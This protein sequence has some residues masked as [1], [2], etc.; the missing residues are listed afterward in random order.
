MDAA[1]Q[2][3]P[4]FAAALSDGFS[5]L[6]EHLLQHHEN[7]IAR[8]K[9]ECGRLQ[10]EVSVLRVHLEKSNEHLLSLDGGCVRRAQTDPASY[11]TRSEPVSVQ[12]A[13]EIP[14]E[15][16][17]SPTVS[18]E[19]SRGTRKG[20][21][22][23][24]APAPLTFVSPAV[25]FNDK[26][27]ISKEGSAGALSAHACPPSPRRRRRG[28]TAFPGEGSRSPTRQRTMEP[29]ARRSFERSKSP[30][31]PEETLAI[32]RGLFD[33]KTPRE[34][35]APAPSEASKGLSSA[36]GS[37]GDMLCVAPVEAGA[38]TQRRRRRPTLT[39]SMSSQL[40][41]GGGAQ[42]EGA[43]QG[44]G[45]GARKGSLG[46]LSV[47]S[48][49]QAAPG[50][51]GAS[52]HSN[53]SSR[54]GDH[55]HLREVWTHGPPK[56][57]GSMAMRAYTPRRAGG[58]WTV[59]PSFRTPQAINMA[60]AFASYSS[61]RGER[62]AF[63]HPASRARLIWELL[64]VILVVYDVLVVPMYPFDWPAESTTGVTDWIGRTFWTA[65]IAMSFLTGVFVDFELE[66]RLREV[67]KRYAKSWMTFDVVVVLSEWIPVLV[68][69]TAA[70]SSALRLLRFA[71]ILRFLKMEKAFEIF[72]SVC[73]SWMA[74]WTNLVARQC[75]YLAAGIHLAACGWFWAGSRSPDGWVARE[76][77]DR[78]DVDYRYLTS[79]HWAVSQLHGASKVGPG[80]T[81]ESLYAILTL[82]LGLGSLC[83]LIAS[84][85]SGVMQLE[86]TRSSAAKQRVLIRT[87]LRKNNI[88]REL[89]LAVKRCSDVHTRAQNREKKQDQAKEAVAFLPLNL[90]M[91]ID[92]EVRGPVVIAYSFFADLYEGSTRI[93]R[94]LCHSCC[95]EKAVRPAEA[96]FAAG[97]DC[98]FMYFVTK[99]AFQY[100][101]ATRREPPSSR[102]AGDS[103]TKR[104]SGMSVLSGASAHTAG[105][106]RS[107]EKPAAPVP[108]YRGERAL[109]RGNWLCEATLW[110]TW[111]HR[112]VLT[113]STGGALLR[114]D[115]AEFGA[116]I[117]KHNAS[118]WAYASRYGR[119]FVRQLNECLEQHSWSDV[120]DGIIMI[121]REEI[122]DDESDSETDQLVE[123]D[124]RAAG[125]PRLSS[126][127]RTSD[128][129]DRHYI[130]IS[131]HKL[132]AGTE[133]TLM[134][135]ALERIIGQDEESPGH[136][137]D[138]PVF[139]D[140]ED[141]S[142]LTNLKDHVR[143]TFN[144]VLLLTEDVLK[145]PWVLIEIV[146][147]FQS[148]IHV[149]PVE[150]YK[151]D[152]NS[153]FKY[154][155]EK[156]YQRLHDGGLLTSADSAL[157]R[158]EGISMD[159]LE[160]ALRHVFRK[161]A[162]PF[163]PHKSQNVREAELTDILNRCT[164]TYRGSMTN[165]SDSASFNLPGNLVGQ[166][167]SFDKHHDSELS[168][169]CGRFEQQQS[170]TTAPSTDGG[171]ASAAPSLT[172][173][174]CRA[175]PSAESRGAGVSPL[176]L[177]RVGEDLPGDAVS[178]T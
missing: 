147:A 60:G 155:D 62:M 84:A 75:L 25:S 111:K 10:K 21:R 61:E 12:D 126:S 78:T 51:V 88:S 102:P 110:T 132:D 71:R 163:S 94:Q 136:H 138:A 121:T 76:N 20:R 6:K 83:F 106:L 100:T 92:E 99:G 45:L 40:A 54:A 153:P 122:L 113:T 31:T 29:Q 46:S 156:F 98:A 142:D 52:V 81:L 28:Q 154:P 127:K 124:E 18:A 152:N 22:S 119:E 50:S 7:E 48:A 125:D 151:R 57:S 174:P 146:T 97:D 101:R 133:A 141:L 58:N 38:E 63:L 129:V 23:K 43:G 73:N 123:D 32:A 171:A 114:L 116:I 56:D 24:E 95:S 160:K 108:L 39:Q 64:T 68:T 65:D 17:Y 105:S 26:D 85:T 70:E 117:L 41:P 79:V 90:R 104:P 167:D 175:Q 4:G 144:L 115:A 33:S 82:L 139:L 109:D 34:E 72:G 35:T 112:G 15:E 59:I 107:A 173:P 158:D 14:V 8:F 37:G 5:G 77:A 91:D 96:V 27:L 49:D 118:A 13:P 178:V 36:P 2:Q 137:M 19:V 74:L 135:E 89:S 93:V 157:I 9:D 67:A 80:N 16:T 120:M 44:L 30:Y 168:E 162:V 103:P 128:Y 66:L 140:S 169:P 86:E 1:P 11:R 164:D 149:V 134:Q 145:R 69:P 131:H 166:T 176:V 143:N 161:I 159:D 53:S 47:E 130:F 148:G 170:S 87:Y 150:I 42:P 172:A 177:E 3:Q 55:F 165:M